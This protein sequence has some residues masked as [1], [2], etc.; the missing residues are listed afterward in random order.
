MVVEGEHTHHMADRRTDSHL[1]WLCPSEAC[2]RHI[3]PSRYRYT[4]TGTTNTSAAATNESKCPLHIN[5]TWQHVS[6]CALTANRW[7]G[8]QGNERRSLRLNFSLVTFLVWVWRAPAIESRSLQPWQP[9]DRHTYAWQ[10]FF[11]S[12]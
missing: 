7:D 3:G 4:I 9:H 5:W 11:C 6:A 10:T 8:R 1:D 2:M 12:L